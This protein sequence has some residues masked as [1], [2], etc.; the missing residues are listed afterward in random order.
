LGVDRVATEPAIAIDY[1]SGRVFV[2][3]QR[4]NSLGEGDIAMRTFVGAPAAGTP[5]LLS[6]NPGSDRAQFYPTVAVDQNTHRVHVSWY[7]QG[8]QGTGDLTEAVH[9]YSNDL[10]TTWTPPTPLLDRP[11]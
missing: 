7:D 11:F 5:T 2:V 8:V 6:S 9:T 3:Y 1:T 10:G 4:N